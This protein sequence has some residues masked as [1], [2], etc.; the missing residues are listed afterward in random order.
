MAVRRG[1]E[2]IR[3]MGGEPCGAL[4]EKKEGGTVKRSRPFVM[5]VR[6]MQ[7]MG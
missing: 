5:E 6:A 7:E 4:A 1:A 2:A 3:T